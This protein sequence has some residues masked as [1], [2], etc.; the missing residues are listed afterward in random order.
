MKTFTGGDTVY[1]FAS[2]LVGDTLTNPTAV[3]AE[4]YDGDGTATTYTYG[5]DAELTRPSTGVYRLELEL[6][7]AGEWIIRFNGTGTAAGSQ[8]VKIQALE[9]PLL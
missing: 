6:D 1:V 4:V 8:E 5:T 7:P 3:T 9:S 2:F